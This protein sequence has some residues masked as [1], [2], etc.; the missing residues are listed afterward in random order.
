MYIHVHRQLLLIILSLVQ[1]GV[2]TGCGQTIYEHQFHIDQDYITEEKV[3]NS[4]VMRDIAQIMRDLEVLLTTQQSIQF[5]V[6]MQNS[7]ETMSLDSILNA[8]DSSLEDM[9]EISANKAFCTLSQGGNLCI[10]IPINEQNEA[11]GYIS[12]WL[13]GIKQ[14]YAAMKSGTPDQWESLK[15]FLATTNYLNQEGCEGGLLFSAQLI[16]DDEGNKYV[17]VSATPTA[18]AINI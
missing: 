17:N 12:G 1:I 5:Q 18:I 14:I 13:K 10:I 6:E 16:V 15:T 9:M 4:M 7:A 8:F 2:L 11:F 3:E